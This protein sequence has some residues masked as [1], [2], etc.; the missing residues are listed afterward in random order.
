MANSSQIIVICGR[1]QPPNAFETPVLQ[2]LR[3]HFRFR[4]QHS[5]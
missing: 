4:S 5:F 3:F 1:A 2:P